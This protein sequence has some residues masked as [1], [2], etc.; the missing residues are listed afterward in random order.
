MTT[1]RSETRAIQ[2]ALPV[3]Y[4][5]QRIWQI[6]PGVIIVAISIVAFER[7]KELLEVTIVSEI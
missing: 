6:R 2:Y 7:Y 3:V 4:N 5:E 1:H